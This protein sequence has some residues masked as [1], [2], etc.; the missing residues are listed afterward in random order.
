LFELETASRTLSHAST[1][2]SKAVFLDFCGVFPVHFT[3]P[4]SLP[5]IEFVMHSMP[6]AHNCT[7]NIKT[8]T[9]TVHCRFASYHFVSGSLQTGHHSILISQKPSS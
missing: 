6:M 1:V 7:L 4:T 3:F 9:L 2:F 8:I 5:N